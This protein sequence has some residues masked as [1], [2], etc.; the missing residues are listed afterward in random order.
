MYRA[1][2]IIAEENYRIQ[3][4][5]YRQSQKIVKRNTK[6]LYY[7]CTNSFF[8]IEQESGSKKYGYSK[9]H[10]PNP[11][12]QMGLFLDGSGLPLAFSL[13]PGNTNE[14]TTRI[15]L[16]K[17]IL[18]DF[19]L[20]KFLVC[21]D[22]GLS[23]LSNRQFNTRGGRGYITTQ[24]L[25][26]LKAHL[27]EWALDPQGWHLA[28][29]SAR[30]DL[31]KVDLEDPK[32][33]DRIY[34]KKRW[35]CEDGLE[36]K[37]LVSFSPKYRKYL[38]TVRGR[39]IERAKSRIETPSKLKQKHKNDPNRF[40][41]VVSATA[42]GELAEIEMY[43]LDEQAISQE[44]IYDGFYAVCTNLEGSEL[45]ILE[46]NRQRWQI[47]AAFRTLKLEF[48]ARPVYLQREDRI[49]AHFTTCFLSL[50]I[51]KLLEQS[52][53]QHCPDADYTMFDVL[54]TLR[55]MDFFLLGNQGYSPAYKRTQI[56]DN[57]HEI[58]NFRTD[59]EGISNKG[60]KEILK[61]SK[62]NM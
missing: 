2:E 50:L 37:M 14:Q 13:S 52:L 51:Y 42:E 18:E 28:G 15:P 21:T 31:R 7:D 39:Q 34:Y 48:E 38:R 40:I 17:R 8:E 4:A 35:I 26:K 54:D 6:I 56:T 24:S 1:L 30:F 62:K 43:D 49:L 36:Q 41:R 44:E 59:Y 29:S 16:E 3:A 46:I 57:L 60:M 47:E 19:E 10:R 9:E 61:Q 33:Q 20:S 55:N 58:V 5:V 11:I 45:D 25:K 27:K 22:A 53:K 23:S 32:E 12:I